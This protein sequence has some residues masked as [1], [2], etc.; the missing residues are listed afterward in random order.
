MRT[1]PIALTIALIFSAPLRSAEPS[2]RD[3]TRTDTILASVYVAAQVADWSQTRQICRYP[4]LHESN[5]FLGDHPSAGAINRHFLKTTILG[6][7]IAYLLKKTC[8]AWVSRAWLAAN[9]GIEIDCIATN[10]RNG[11]KIQFGVTF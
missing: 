10:Y 1:R 8:P 7:S 11:I 3:W 6:L 2:S 4:N 9:I 5:P